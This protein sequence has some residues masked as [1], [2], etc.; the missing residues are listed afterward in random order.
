MKFTIFADK[1][2]NTCKECPF[3]T[4]T[5]EER[6]PPNF[7]VVSRCSFGN[8]YENLTCPLSIGDVLEIDK[9]FPINVL[10]NQE[11]EP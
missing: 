1:K 9:I 10:F 2:P 3:Y 7:E 8:N 11:E 5:L 4:Q 6:E